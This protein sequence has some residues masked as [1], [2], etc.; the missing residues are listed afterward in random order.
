MRRTIEWKKM[1]DDGTKVEMRVT[2][3]G[4]EKIRWQRKDP[5]NESWEYDFTPDSQDWT[6]LLD[7][8]E[9]RY[10]RGAIPFNKLKVIRRSTGPDGISKG[11]DKCS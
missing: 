4:H 9:A 1:L 6:E 7:R 8:A 3:P 2:F 5:R 10:T 11:S